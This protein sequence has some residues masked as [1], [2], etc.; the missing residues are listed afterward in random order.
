MSAKA[1]TMEGRKAGRGGRATPWLP[2][3]TGW[4]G[5][6]VGS[7]CEGEDGKGEAGSQESVQRSSQE[8]PCAQNP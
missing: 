6:L 8:Q 7:R 5:S 1:P 3:H 4:L 2:C